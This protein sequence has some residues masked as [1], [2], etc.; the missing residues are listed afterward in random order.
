MSIEN[1]FGSRFDDQSHGDGNANV[2]SG[3]QGDDQITGRGGNENL[4]GGPGDDILRGHD[5]IDRLHGGSGADVVLFAQ[6]KHTGAAGKDTVIDFQDAQ[7]S[8]IC[9]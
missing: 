5:G 6:A 3:G 2:I 7:T 1:L 4:R 9:A 8:S